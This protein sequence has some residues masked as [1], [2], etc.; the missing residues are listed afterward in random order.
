MNKLN[1]WIQRWGIACLLTFGI[2]SAASAVAWPQVSNCWAE[3]TSW[4]N[5]FEQLQAKFFPIN[6]C[7]TPNEIG[8]FL[9]G[10]FAPIAFIW[11]AFAVILQ[12]KELSK[13]REEL[14]LAREVAE[15]S[16]EATKMQAS[17]ARRS[18]EYFEIQTE[19]MKV[20]QV[21]KSESDASSDLD[22]LL[23]SI[24]PSISIVYS[25][26][27]NDISDRQYFS[28]HCKVI[29][30]T[31]DEYLNDAM[32][33]KPTQRRR[34]QEALYSLPAIEEALALE[35]Q[36]GQ[37]DKAVFRTLDLRG[38]A[39]HLNVVKVAFLEG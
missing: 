8:D 29:C 32:A 21:S 26:H 15:Q 25:P 34:L 12:S 3:W 2:L 27:N 39:N 4:P 31:I 14:E 33:G 38:I 37:A 36:L 13:Q 7:M 1:K 24:R 18:A 35:N 20:E 9:A 11:L 23:S 19:M 30:I 22:K 16:L 5:W 6:L 28:Q 17:E 10:V